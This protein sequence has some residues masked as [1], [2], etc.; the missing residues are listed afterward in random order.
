MHAV[1]ILEIVGAIT[2]L[3]AFT[4]SQTG[5][6]ATKTRSYQLLNLVGSAVLA[7]IA[8]VQASWGFLLLEGTWA[9]VSLFGLI[10]VLRRKPEPTLQH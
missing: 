1:D 2:I 7:A 4:A 5:R 8:L 9:V 3:I 6:L 10:A